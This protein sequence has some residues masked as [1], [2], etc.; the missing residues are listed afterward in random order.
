MRNNILAFFLLSNIFLLLEGFPPELLLFW[1]LALVAYLFLY[2]RVFGKSIDFF[3]PLN[4]AFIQSLLIPLII[5]FPIMYFYPP[6]DYDV[7]DVYLEMIVLV[8]VCMSLLMVGVYLNKVFPGIIKLGSFKVV[9]LE[10]GLSF[11]LCLLYGVGLVSKLVIFFT[12]FTHLPDQD[13]LIQNAGKLSFLTPLTRY[14]EYSILILI[15]L[16][17]NKK[18]RFLVIVLIITLILEVV[19]GFYYG[20]R[21]KIIQ[22]FLIALFGYHYVFKRLSGTFFVT[23]ALIMVVVIIPIITSF[24]DNYQYLIFTE[25]QNFSKVE[26]IKKALNNET[27]V[28]KDIAFERSTSRVYSALHGFARVYQEV[29]RN[30]E[31]R[32]GETFF[33][34]IFYQLIPKVLMPEKEIYV[35]GRE[36]ATK[37]YNYQVGEKFGTSVEVSVFGELFYNFGFIGI[38]IFVPLLAFLL[39]SIYNGILEDSKFDTFPVVRYFLFF[40]IIGYLLASGI[41]T[42]YVEFI[43]EI[44][45]FSLFMIILTKKFP[46]KY[47]SKLYE[48]TN[49]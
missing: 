15:V 36:F 46:K 37:F 2:L 28:E 20:N 24:K 3:D 12:G 9:S 43:K 7:S 34:G 4:Y 14:C 41:Q 48:F 6:F 18:S 23:A 1:D 25:G 45:F 13:I 8:A 40:N 5:G 32:N 39:A 29:P 21:T 44:I 42:V 11:R 27:E 38:F 26:L 49:K 47:S 31:Y 33:P 35:P 22:P 19:W 30:I 10:D 16:V 17:K